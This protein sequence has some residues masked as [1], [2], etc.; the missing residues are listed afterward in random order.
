MANLVP[1][2]HDPFAAAGAMPA[3]T[4][5]VPVDHDPFAEPAPA[6]PNMGFAP[7]EVRETPEPV[8]AMTALGRG[9]AQGATFGFADEMNAAAAAS[10]LPGADRMPRL[11][12][13]NAID[14]IAGG[15]RLLAEK[16]A[17]SIF[18]SGGGRA[19]ETEAIRRR[20][21]L[22]Q[23]RAQQPVAAYGGEIAGGLALPLGA[24]G[25]AAT[26]GQA[27]MQG[28]KVGAI[29]GGLYGAGQGEGVE[30][31]VS[32]A[33]TGALVGAGLGGTLGAV[34]GPGA[35]A[36]SSQ[37]APA[38]QDVAAAAE[39]IGVAVP[40]AV[41]S[42]STA[43]QRAGQGV[44][45]IPFAGDPLVKA[46]DKMVQGLGSA[47]DDVTRAMGSGDRA[48]A[49]ATA[50]GAIRDWIT[51]KSAAAV[52]K[53]YDDVEKV[54][55]PAIRSP[56][57]ATQQTVANILA[58]RQNANI[59][60]DSKAVNE[61]LAAA[62]NPQGLNFAGIKDLRTRIG[63]FM[64]GGVLPA[65]MSG[66]E[67]KSIYGALSDDLRNAAEAAGGPRGRQV[68]ER[69]NAFNAAVSKRREE[70][71]KIIGKD[72]NAPAEQVFDT[73]VRYAGE[74]GG[75]DISRLAKAKNAIGGDWD[76][77]VSGV[78]GRMG[79]D[80]EGNFTPDRFA[81]AWG[82]LSSSGKSLLFSNS[83]HRSALEDIFTI[84]AKAKDSYKRFGNPSGTAQN[85][86]FAAGVAGLL[87]DP[88]TTIG[89]VAGGNVLSRILAQ[90]ATASSMARWS[91][92]YTAAVTKPTAATAAT[93]Q[94]ATRNLAA[95]IGDNL[96]VKIAPQEIIRAISGPR[97]APA[98]D[99][100]PQQEEQN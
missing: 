12:I 5:L 100:Q 16:I 19:Y 44:R 86:G 90:P 80:A 52:S 53:A 24:A 56:L 6:S 89:V 36:A 17:P 55:D 95:T 57:T 33:A 29:G 13:P 82:S 39:R 46:T 26:R 30:G 31:T 2:D 48:Q 59:Q 3:A 70:L 68:F 51:G 85:V 60:G 69:A 28:A 20:E 27:A 37:A 98:S 42:D 65:D 50:S 79:R 58:R 45:N 96:G 10:P 54:V 78:V 15:A 63:E 87:A 40:R 72:G 11:A 32:G 71:A 64:K 7:R 67:L 41:A 61:V 97:V 88:I 47:A 92:V 91:R 35:S 81:T 84:S 93:L 21:E 99:G 77:V 9:A 25:Q 74:K 62:Q 1:V 83:A 8:S 14:T 34:I 73:I 75:A 66:S 18:G 4:N 49:G 38:G 22:A 76:E 23:A 43:V 94:V